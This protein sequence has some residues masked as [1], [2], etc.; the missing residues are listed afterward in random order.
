MIYKQFSVKNPLSGHPSC[1]T[2]AVRDYL[3]LQK[4]KRR[5]SFTWWDKGLASACQKSLL[6]SQAREPRWCLLSGCVLV[7]ETGFLQQEE[8]CGLPLV[9]DS[10]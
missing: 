10:G 2:P 4:G 8:P 1:G 6:A 3:Y 5:H 7:W 9:L